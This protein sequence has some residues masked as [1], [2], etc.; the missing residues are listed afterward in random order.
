MSGNHERFL[1]VIVLNERS[2]LEL[3]TSGSHALAI[4]AGETVFPRENTVVLDTDGNRIGLQQ[5]SH[6]VGDAQG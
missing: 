3:Y 1:V 2:K 6:V 5:L 4:L